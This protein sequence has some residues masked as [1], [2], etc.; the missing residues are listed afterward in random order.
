MIVP[1]SIG[2]GAASG[3]DVPGNVEGRGSP[4]SGPTCGGATGAAGVTGAWPFSVDGI[5]GTAGLGAIVGEAVLFLSIAAV[6]ETAPPVGTG[7]P[8]LGVGGV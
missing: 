3:W 5:A 1:G 8:I 4:A 6:V 7:A 2:S